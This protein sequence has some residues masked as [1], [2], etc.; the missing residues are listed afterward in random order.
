MNILLNKPSSKFIFTSDL[1]ELHNTIS[2]V[3]EPRKFSFA[4]AHRNALIKVNRLALRDTQIFRV[5]ST[6]SVQVRTE[7]L[8]SIQVDIPIKGSIHVCS[9]GNEKCIRPGEAI[10]HIAGESLDTTWS[11]LCHTIIVR[12][13][14][15]VLAPLIGDL[16][17]G[18]YW[19]HRS[20]PH[21]LSL[22]HGLGKSMVDLMNQICAEHET[23]IEICD[24]TK[25][26][27]LLHYILALIITK[28]QFV[29]VFDQHN[30]PT[31]PRYLN[32]AVNYLIENLE[33]E[34]SLKELGSIAHVSV[35]TLQR[36]FVSHFGKGPMK[37]IKHAR[38][39]KVREELLASSA[40]EKSVSQ[41]A[42][43][44]GFHHAGNFARNY[45][46]LFGENPLQTLRHVKA[47]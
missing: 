34:I 27:K 20:E 39:H 17:Q 18:K 36:A 29:H 9:F 14:P 24:D 33:Q 30:L 5:E 6:S 47:F 22:S 15:K 12:I 7:N 2:N 10:I 16:C 31:S 40:C 13:E 46:E 11:D 1:E 8:N 26:D 43:K 28:N 35:R 3:I 32:R 4:G 41:I 37:F 23:D 25:L 45:C 19:T 21:V 42:S 44:W 38:L